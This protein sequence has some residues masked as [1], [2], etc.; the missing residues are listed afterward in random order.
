MNETVILD[1]RNLE[2]KLTLSVIIPVYNTSIFV[3][4]TLSSFDAVGN[5]D[6]EIIIVNDGSTDNSINVVSEW[7]KNYHGNVVLISQ[8]IKG[9]RKRVTL[10]CDMHVANIFHFAIVMTG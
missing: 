10:L 4:R 3:T 2:T 6:I 8:K 7:I 9:C 5:K 1:T